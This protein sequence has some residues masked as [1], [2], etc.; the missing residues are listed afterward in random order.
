V[1]GSTEY[2]IIFFCNWT[3]NPFNT[4][5]K[6]F[7]HKV[8]SCH[9]ENIVY[10]YYKYVNVFFWLQMRII[11]LSV[12]QILINMCLFLNQLLFIQYTIM[13]APFSAF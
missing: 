10:E 1:L 13:Y 8:L 6:I 3:I 7:L 12:L 2:Y 5:L 11:S 9:A 4:D